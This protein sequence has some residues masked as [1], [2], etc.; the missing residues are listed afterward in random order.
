MLFTYPRYWKFEY[1][2]TQ[3]NDGK[4]TTE[5]LEK[6][7]QRK[8][9]KIQHVHS[10]A[11]DI[12]WPACSPDLS[13]LDFWFWGDMETVF[14]EKKPQAMQQIQESVTLETAAIDPSKVIRASQNF[15]RRVELCRNRTSGH[16]EAEIKKFKM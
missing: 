7:R 16:F 6:G 4:T 5:K 1:L 13:P 2:P 11:E 10:R 14:R 8:S 12:P 15:R 9:Q 3:S